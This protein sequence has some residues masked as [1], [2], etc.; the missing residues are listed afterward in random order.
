MACGGTPGV[1]VVTELRPQ[2]NDFP[3][4]SPREDRGAP[5]RLLG[6]S[7]SAS[8]L[9]P[10]WL[11]PA[12]PC[13]PQKAGLT[14]PGLGPLPGR[15][16]EGS[17]RRQSR[18]GRLGWFP[19]DPLGL[20]GWSEMDTTRPFEL[21]ELQDPAACGV[22]HLFS[23]AGTAEC[24][25]ESG[26]GSGRCWSPELLAGADSYRMQV[27]TFDSQTPFGP[28]LSLTMCT[29]LGTKPLPAVGCPTSG[30]CGRVSLS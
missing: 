8:F 6:A 2:A 1:L 16:G 23:V 28:S 21:T 7:R 20:G 18:C 25:Q 12:P 29:I 27:Q 24:P 14:Q 22:P 15:A 11:C 13:F 19:A 3:R 4:Q 26:G 17:S 5:P 9:F 10:R 30:A